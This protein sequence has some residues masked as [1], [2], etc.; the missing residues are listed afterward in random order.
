MS[1]L[2]KVTF[3]YNPENGEIFNATD[4]LLKNMAKNKLMVCPEEVLR[5][6]RPDLF[7]TTAAAVVAATPVAPPVQPVPA[8]TQEPAGDYLPDTAEDAQDSGIVIEVDPN[9]QI[10]LVEAIGKLDPA[11]DYTKAGV[12][13]PRKLSAL[14][15]SQVTAMERDLAFAEFQKEQKQG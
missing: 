12:P 4:D 2:G 7:G 11:V 13:D 14:V 6:K 8:P 10:L 5:A 3:V 9:R 15:G 1:G